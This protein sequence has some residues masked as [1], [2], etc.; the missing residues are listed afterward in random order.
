MRNSSGRHAPTLFALLA[1][2]LCATALGLS[3]QQGASQSASP[4]T[5]PPANQQSASPQPPANPQANPPPIPPQIPQPQPQAPPP[6][7]LSVIVLDPGHGGA[8]PGAR[9]ANGVV[10]KDA[11]LIFARMLRSDL[12]RAGF[13]VVMTRDGDQNPSFDDRAAVANALRG[14]IFISLH[15]SS[16][17]QVGTVRAYSYQF[18]EAPEIV[19]ASS[20]APAGSVTSA[21]SSPAIAPLPPPPPPKPAPAGWILWETAQKSYQDISRRLAD[22]IQSELAQKFPGSPQIS[23]PVAV[24]ELRSVTAPAVA[25]EISSVAVGDAGALQA[26]GSSLSSAIVRA[27]NAFKPVYESGSK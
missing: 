9:G 24:R 23:T 20:P 26:M 17:G 15:V 7:G 14:A 10:E 22:L 16:T 11:V 21:G 5:I 1:L 27:V 18:S 13:R 4:Q 12:E 6:R 3:A 25:V 19:P 8:D 2:I